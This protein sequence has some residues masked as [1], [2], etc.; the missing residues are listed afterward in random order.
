MSVNFVYIFAPHHFKA[1]EVTHVYYS[2]NDFYVFDNIRLNDFASSCMDVLA[3]NGQ[4][5]IN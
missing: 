3:I 1:G 5:S 4:I 2:F